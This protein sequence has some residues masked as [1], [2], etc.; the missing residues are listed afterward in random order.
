MEEAPTMKWAAAD[1][2]QIV[3]QDGLPSDG[4]SA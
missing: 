2:A 4:Y 3:L 1:V